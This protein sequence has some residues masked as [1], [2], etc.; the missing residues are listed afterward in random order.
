M[1]LCAGGDGHSMADGGPSYPGHGTDAGVP[2]AHVGSAAGTK[3]MR[4]LRQ[5]EWTLSPRIG[6]LFLFNSLKDLTKKSQIYS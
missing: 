5:C 4:R 6:F 2:H 1:R 3:D